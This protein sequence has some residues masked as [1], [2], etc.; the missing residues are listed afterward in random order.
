MIQRLKVRGLGR[1]EIKAVVPNGTHTGLRTATD[2]LM[3]VVRRQNV[4]TV[5]GERGHTGVES[6]QTPLQLRGIHILR[7]KESCRV[8]PDA[9]NVVHD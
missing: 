7:R 6:L 2:R 8:H 5:I 9:G 3:G 4:V 1:R